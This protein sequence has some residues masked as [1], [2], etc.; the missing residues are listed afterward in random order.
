M[1]TVK[2]TTTIKYV[3]QGD[4]VS[5]QLRSTLPL[6]QFVANGTGL[7]TPDFTSSSP[8]IYPVIR[9]SLMAARVQPLQTGVVWKFEGVELSF[10]ADG[11][12]VANGAIAAGSFKSEWK[13]VDGDFSV[14]TLTILK[15]I[16]SSSVV[17]SKTIEFICNVNTGFAAQ[18]SSCIE[19]SIEQTD[20][21]AYIGYIS[22]NDGGVIDDNTP[23]LTLTANLMVA[24]SLQSSGV[25]YQWKKLVVQNGADTWQALSGK[26]NK[27]LSPITAA[28]IDNHEIYKCE[29]SCGGRT[30]DAVIEVSDET[31]PRVVVPNPTNG[32][33]SVPEELSTA[34]QSIIYQP[35]VVK[36]GT[37]THVSG[38]R[39]WFTLTDNNGNIIAEADNALQFTV[40]LAHAQSA[41][42]NLSLLI[43]ASDE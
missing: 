15:D 37:E 17:T 30:V 35:F 7:V 40:T 21:D 42:G 9:S 5:C 34:Q 12:N 43:T 4:T 20:G 8:C 13:T 11:L 14:P 16:A 38:F 27:T 2:G 6:K 22:V 18:V 10:G 24:G 33:T 19:V 32:T 28:D 25:T 26:T 36:R 1:S 29:M 23:Q 39:F 31:D 41:G 3:R